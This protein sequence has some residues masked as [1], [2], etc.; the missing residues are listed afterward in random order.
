[1]RTGNFRKHSHENDFFVNDICRNLVGTPITIPGSF[2]ARQCNLTSLKGMPK[3]VGFNIDL[4]NNHL[5]ELI[6]VQEHV[7]GLFNVD[8]NKLTSFKGGPKS[9]VDY[10]SYSGNLIP[11]LNDLD[12]VKAVTF[13]CDGNLITS[14]C[15]I[16]KHIKSCYEIN[17]LGLNLSEGGLGLLLISDIS[18]I[19]ANIEPLKIIN[20]YTG[21]GKPGILQC[22]RDLIDA[23]FEEYAEL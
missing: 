11:N 13:Y 5:K 10:I 23:G 15:G 18:H 6:G 3:S 20:K 1:M 17:L 7:N 22:Q 21:Q 8:N 4:A 12:I 2:Y 14:L 16:H 9:A 19:F